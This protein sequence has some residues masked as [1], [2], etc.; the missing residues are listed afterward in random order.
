MS[1]PSGIEGRTAPNRVAGCGLASV[2][3]TADAA[4]DFS[5]EYALCTS[6]AFVLLGTMLN[7]ALYFGENGS[8]DYW[9]MVI[10]NIELLKLTFIFDL[11]FCEVVL[12]K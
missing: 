4:A 1:F 10:G 5:G 3:L 2:V 11:A 6:A 12:A 7:L 8:G 9:F